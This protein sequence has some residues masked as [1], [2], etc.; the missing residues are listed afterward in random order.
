MST[1]TWNKLRDGSWGLRSEAALTEGESVLVSR[2]DG[3][4]SKATVGRRVWSGN[5][6][7]LYGVGTA[8]KVEVAPKAAP[9][10]PKPIVL[11]WSVAE[12][13]DAARESAAERAAELAAESA[14]T[15]P[16]FCGF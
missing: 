9:E 14:L 6:V 8:P 3:S 15:D 13:E 16:D 1:I 4:R 7:W 5:G 10:A 11:D 2:K 12:A